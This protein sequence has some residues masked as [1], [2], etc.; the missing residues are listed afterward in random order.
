[1]AYDKNAK[2]VDPF[3]AA[4][5]EER[6]ARHLGQAEFAVSIQCNPATM[7]QYENG[8]SVPRVD[9]MRDWAA[10]LDHELQLVKVEK[11][12]RGRRK[13]QSDADEIP[14]DLMTVYLSRYQTALG[15]GML[16][17]QAAQARA[18]GSETLAD[19]L[20]IIADILARSIH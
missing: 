14:E 19:D 10:A 16:V 9:L 20:Q 13:A 3:V 7:S 15:M 6:L 17:A 4:L 1:M 11:P 5:K 12:T 2:K 18:N 8:G